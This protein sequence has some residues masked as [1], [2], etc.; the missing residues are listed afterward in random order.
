MGQGYMAWRSQAAPRRVP[1]DKLEPCQW[2][3]HVTTGF[4]YSDAQLILSADATLEIGFKK[5]L[6]SSDVIA[7]VGIKM[8]PAL[9]ADVRGHTQAGDPEPCPGRQ[10]EVGED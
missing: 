7:S 3:C 10:D 6:A 2:R 5:H 9:Q 1:R 8:V 4:S